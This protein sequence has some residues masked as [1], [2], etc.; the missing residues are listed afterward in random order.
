MTCRVLRVDGGVLGGFIVVQKSSASHPIL[1][2]CLVIGIESG[3][4][5]TDLPSASP[6]LSGWSYCSIG[7]FDLQ[8]KWVG[9]GL[10]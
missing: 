8:T 7:G 1:Y 5:V 9:V 6:P 2:P 3:A 4:L 10:S